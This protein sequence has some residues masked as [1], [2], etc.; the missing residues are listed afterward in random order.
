M[1]SDASKTSRLGGKATRHLFRSQ[2]KHFLRFFYEHGETS[3]SLASFHL[4]ITL[5]KHDES[6]LFSNK[7]KPPTEQGQY[8]PPL[9]IQPP[10]LLKSHS[11]A[12]SLS[13][14]SNRRSN[15]HPNGPLPTPTKSSPT[16]L[17][18]PRSNDNRIPINQHVPTLDPQNYQHEL[19]RTGQR[20]LLLSR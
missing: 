17:I 15:S 10:H 2:I 9:F 7:Q 13:P 5:S 16:F 3:I 12:F 20:S 11:L 19:G 6:T 14:R 8:R 4:T 18:N 1:D